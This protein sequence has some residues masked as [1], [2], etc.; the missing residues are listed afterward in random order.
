MPEEAENVEEAQEGAEEVQENYENG[1]N[2]MKKL[3]TDEE[4]AEMS[5]EE[6]IT[7]E[8]REE[9]E[10]ELEAFKEEY[11]PENEDKVFSGK[12]DTYRDD[13]GIVLV[14]K[15]RVD[16]GGR[17]SKE[18]PLELEKVTFKDRFYARFP[19]LKE[20]IE[21]K[22]EGDVSDLEMIITLQD[23]SEEE[24]DKTKTEL[25][26][27]YKRLEKFLEI[28][29]YE[30]KRQRGGERFRSFFRELCYLFQGCFD[31]SFGKWLEGRMTNTTRKTLEIGDQVVLL[32]HGMFQNDGSMRY[33]TKH[34]RNCGYKVITVG[35]DYNLKPEEAAKLFTKITKDIYEKTG[36]RPD[37]IGHS[38]GA[39]N[40]LYASQYVASYANKIIAI[41]PTT[42]GLIRKTWEH[43]LMGGIPKQ[44]SPYYLEGRENILNKNRISSMADR[45]TVV[46]G[47]YDRLVTIPSSFYLYGRNLV[48]DGMTHWDGAGGN[49]FVYMDAI[50]PLIKGSKL[51]SWEPTQR[52][53]RPDYVL[54]VKP[55]GEE[56]IAKEP[57]ATVFKKAA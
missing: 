23:L 19:P 53:Y 24:M 46:L 35:Y 40:L 22:Y 28:A 42:N 21:M 45:V 36:V 33:A 56:L 6:E 55:R 2:G 32:F 11:N 20:I 8:E 30:K 9:E 37:L 25:A 29:G 49:L 52:G 54:N 16:W 44:D 3:Y 18:D 4:A 34:L 41:S 1:E 5:K 57:N 14:D 50:E 47:N 12:P 10:E 51:V 31:I 48:V 43:P 38:T 15:N 27:K 39:D 26:R 7:E 13:N 17:L